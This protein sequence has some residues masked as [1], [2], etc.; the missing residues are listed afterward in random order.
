MD[1][2]QGADVKGRKIRECSPAYYSSCLAERN[3]VMY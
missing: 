3:E 1:S 2:L